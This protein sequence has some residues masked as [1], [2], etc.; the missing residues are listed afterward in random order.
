MQETTSTLLSSK[1]IVKSSFSSTYSKENK[2]TD[3]T[4]G[5]LIKGSVRLVEYYQFIMISL[6]IHLTR[7]H[8]SRFCGHCSYCGFPPMT[9]CL[10][11][12]KTNVL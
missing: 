6:S 12:F 1:K 10:D 4:K 5:N 11:T 2:R 3:K 9:L 8:S 7:Q